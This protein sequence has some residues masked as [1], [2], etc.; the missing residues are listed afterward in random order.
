MSALSKRKDSN[1]PVGDVI[2]VYEYGLEERG[3]S[4]TG[5]TDFPF[6]LCLYTSSG[7]HSV[8][9]TFGTRSP[10][11][12]RKARLERDADHSPPSVRETVGALLPK[13]SPWR[14]AGKPKI[15]RIL[16]LYE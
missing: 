14:V 1:K 2:T 6:N 10:Y 8:S 9:Y 4:L 5:N 16:S 11:P 13:V 7:A 3:Q 12:G 15:L